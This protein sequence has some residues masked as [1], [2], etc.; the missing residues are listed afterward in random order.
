V[1]VA[2][3]APLR[4]RFAAYPACSSNALYEI[5]RFPDRLKVIDDEDR[6]RNWTAADNFRT[7]SETK[8][9]ANN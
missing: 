9:C 8:Q 5:A 6:Q 7:A 2:S 1:G 4:V 3:F